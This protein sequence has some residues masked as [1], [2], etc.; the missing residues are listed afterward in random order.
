MKKTLHR[1]VGIKN[2][3]GCRD[4]SPCDYRL[5]D[6]VV[7]LFVYDSGQGGI[8][9]VAVKHHARPC[10]AGA[11]TVAILEDAHGANVNHVVIGIVLLLHNEAIQSILYEHRMVIREASRRHLV[12][13]F[14]FHHLLVV[15]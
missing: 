7:R 4:D 12:F 2:H 10:N 14:F 15:T 13:I 1:P 6:V 11:E 3:R 8:V 5:L 9:I